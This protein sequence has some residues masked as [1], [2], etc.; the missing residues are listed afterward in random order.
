MPVEFLHDVF[1]FP[2][3]VSF[4]ND[5]KN[6]FEIA[7]Q[8]GTV[9]LEKWPQIRLQSQVECSHVSEPDALYIKN[10]KNSDFEKRRIKVEIL[11]HIDITFGCNRRHGS[12][13]GFIYLSV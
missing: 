7:E 1:E 8:S 9:I 10:V 3:Y 11:R 6:N 2:H 13:A 12:L 4:L 5:L